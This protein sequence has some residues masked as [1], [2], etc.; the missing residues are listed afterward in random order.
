M[1]ENNTEFKIQAFKGD[2]TRFELN[3]LDEDPEFTGKFKVYGVGETG[4]KDTTVS[5]SS[6]ISQCCCHSDISEG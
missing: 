1:G 5:W 4:T 3:G 2:A 6:L